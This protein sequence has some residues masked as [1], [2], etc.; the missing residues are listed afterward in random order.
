[1]LG[2][3]GCEVNA[4]EAQAPGSHK[5]P[6]WVRERCP[7]SVGLEGAILPISIKSGLPIGRTWQPSCGATV[8]TR[9][10]AVDVW[11]WWQASWGGEAIS[12]EP[13]GRL[14]TFNR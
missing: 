7:I 10:K 1:M 5:S 11:N 6:I 12:R 8:P 9:A 4:V 3:Y 14:L 13:L 2:W